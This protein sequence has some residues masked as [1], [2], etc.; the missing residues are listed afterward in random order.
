MSEMIPVKDRVWPAEE[1]LTMACAIYRTKG[2]TS[3]STYTSGEPDSESRWNNKEHLCYQMVPEIADKEYKVLINVIQE[4]VDTA[5]AIVQHYRRL[6][7]GV[8]ADNL[9]D[10]MQRVFSSTQKPEVRFSDFGILASVPS[11][12]EKEINKKRIEKEA[13]NTKQ[14]YIGKIGDDV[15]LEIRYINTRVV[16]KLNCYAHDA[17][18][19]DGYLVNFLSKKQLGKPGTVHKIRAKVKAHGINFQ[20]KTMET[21]LNYVKV[22]DMEFVW[23]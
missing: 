18:T 8:I 3:V 15:T 4:D 13:K 21:Q 23:Q 9:N 1:A 17:V 7:F 16:Q 22:L 2:Y 10:Y 14:E 12:Y 11:A 5:N 6:T 19:S 20:T